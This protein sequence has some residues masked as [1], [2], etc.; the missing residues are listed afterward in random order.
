MLHPTQ[1]EEQLEKLQIKKPEAEQLKRIASLP[2][3]LRPAAYAVLNRDAAGKIASRHYNQIATSKVELMRLPKEDL[4]IIL[5]AFFPM[6]AEEVLLALKFAENLPYQAGYTQ[7]AFRYSRNNPH[8]F[9]VSAKVFS[10]I[11]NATEDYDQ[12]IHWFSQWAPY[13]Y[14]GRNLGT[15]FAAVID[16]GGERGERVYQ[17]MLDSA[18]GTHPIG[19]MG[20]H[21]AGALLMAS[22]PDGWEFMEKT[23]L[24][25]QRQEGLR[26]SIL[27]TVD[28]AH[29]T[30]FR[31]MLRL[32]LEHELFRFSAV[33][34]AFDLWLGFYFDVETLK[35]KQG[36]QMLSKL[37]GYIEEPE[38]RLQAALNAEHSDAYMALCAEGFENVDSAVE[39]AAQ[40]LD[41]HET[42]RRY[43]AIAFLEAAAT[44]EAVLAA[45]RAIKD[46]DLRIAYKAATICSSAGTGNYFDPT[47][48]EW[49][50]SHTAPLKDTGIDLFSELTSLL[51]RLPVKEVVLEPIVWE[52]TGVKIDR[53]DI[54]NS[55]NW[56]MQDRPATD[57]IPYLKLMAASIRGLALEKIVKLKPVTPQ[58]RTVL[59]DAFGDTSEDVRKAVKE[60]VKKLTLT[61]TEILNMERLLTRK[62]ADLRLSALEILLKQ[63]D[64]AS[65]ASAD[66]LLKSVAMQR[67][68]G[69]EILSQMASK[70][71]SKSACVERAAKY[72][73]DS[74]KLE[75]AEQVLLE[76]LLKEDSIVHGHDISQQLFDPSLCTPHTRKRDVP[77]PLID[78][79]APEAC[80]ESLSQLYK[81]HE[82][83][84]ITVRRYDGSPVEMLLCD[85]HLNLPN[86]AASLV[87]ENEIEEE[88]NYGER[89]GNAE[90][91]VAQEEFSFPLSEIWE[92]WSLK[93]SAEL[94]DE[95]GLE[96]LRLLVALDVEIASGYNWQKEPGVTKG[97]ADRIKANIGD[98]KV[99]FQHRIIVAWLL[100]LHPPTG[101]SDYLLNLLEYLYS[102]IPDEAILSTGTGKKKA[103][104]E[105][106][107]EWR[108]VY[109]LNSLSSTT[110]ETVFSLNPDAWTQSQKAR[111]W[112]LTHWTDRPCQSAQ[113]RLPS[114]NL[115]LAAYD[116]GIA[117]DADLFDHLIGERPALPKE[118]IDFNY[119]SMYSAYSELEA[120]TRR[121][122][123]RALA[124]HVPL[125]KV[126]DQI[127]DRCI[128]VE[129]S[130]GELP[131][132]VSE[133]AMSL[134][135]VKGSE[136]LKRF[137]TKF[138]NKEPFVRN[139]DHTNLTR[140]AVFSH[141]IRICS[142]SESDTYEQFAR[143]LNET[144][145]T[146]LRLVELAVFA[147]QW[148]VWVEKY[149]G[150]ELLEE[151]VWWLHAHT[152]DVGWSVDNALKEEWKAK[153]AT[154]TPLSGDD[155]IDGAADVDW[156]RRVFAAMEGDRWKMLDSAAKYASGGGGQKRAQLYADAMRGAL[157]EESLSARVADKRNLDAVR[158]IGLLPIPADSKAKETLLRRYG[159]LQEFIRTSRQFGA[160]RQ[161]SEKRAANIGK[162]N[163]SRSAGFADP[164]RLSW[165][166]EAE[167]VSDLARG[168]ISVSDGEVTITLSI[169]PDGK[170][171]LSVTKKGK[172]LKSIP[173]ALKKLPEIIELIER[174]KEI[175]KQS[176][177]MKRS[178]E[179]AM[180][181][182]DQ[183]Q[184][185]ELIE[186][187]KLP[188]LNPLLA[189]LVFVGERIAGCPGPDGTSLIDH[190]DSIHAIQAS[191]KLRLAHPCDLA[192]TGEWHL[193]QTH[194]YQREL[195][196][197]FKQ[198]FRELYTLLPVETESGRLRSSRYEGHQVMPRQGMA[199]LGG[200][201]WVNS[202]EEGVRRT[203]HSEKIQA[204]I[205]F[206]QYF[207]TPAEV[208][209]LTVMNV[210]FAKRNDSKRIPLRDVP[211]RL[212]SE[213]MRDI[214]LMVSVAHAGGVDPEASQSTVEMRESLLRETLRWLKISNVSYTGS[215]AL[216]K[217]HLGDYSIHMGSGVVHRQPGGYLCIVPVSSQHRG[218]LFLPFADN[219]P[220]TAEVISKVLLLA[221]DEEIRDP[222]ILQQIL[223]GG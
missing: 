102:L 186:L 66:R 55:L 129:L 11:L 97:I 19:A 98:K 135:M 27:E 114:I 155:L 190:D 105:F 175:D 50:P 35:P 181:R 130:R 198:L 200:R 69:L 92:E 188:A 182:G 62:T 222:I 59:L 61:D 80:L 173:P 70:E 141:F 220:K 171:D 172:P 9:E 71:R 101:A 99:N 58:V 53:S 123:N 113:R 177:R 126:V 120:C 214:D 205:E 203:F 5:P 134:Q 183:F 65:L 132:P 161:E 36:S 199:L 111:L 185:D 6:F 25:A 72:Q 30:A 121:R 206:E 110:I 160:Q 60:A 201:G 84:P 140:Q 95:D 208:E 108:D 150:W 147:P 52:W 67:A 219:D 158:A 82:K 93:R 83:T 33:L 38:T 116:H 64:E 76:G 218:R 106:Q 165:A 221:K 57:L 44:A 187:M 194:C 81:Q 47:D 51:E 170:P 41:H 119:Y 86:T 169:A 143:Q 56:S 78:T 91:S 195:A 146:Q 21:V 122:P 48:M 149:L 118:Y 54:A 75:P 179:E 164:I 180:C 40:I 217:G 189:K 210:S 127:R 204:H 115:L 79:S 163:L 223:P 34:R 112:Q 213:T 133:Q 10:D 209:G 212:F 23:L 49:K 24:A 197:P 109:A 94:R 156:F 28:L 136:T 22:R 167:A 89:Q 4:R 162:E 43:I 20:F 45:S 184:G 87:A 2:E 13:F 191:D 1:A 138:G 152:K 16:A 193:W 137:L 166:M 73:A 29:P 77:R 14:N 90:G 176:S 74:K 178:L 202:A 128:E 104:F 159:I 37:L 151:S 8:R 18:R 68:A 125:M 174:K 100:K 154:Y 42:E 17:T 15:L 39:I 32:I 153:A 196:Q 96:L 88:L 107:Q 131:T 31:R 148:A 3:R 157:T 207:T 63:S 215:H 139:A 85:A 144:N 26:Q 145:V 124:D 216:V 192:R 7:K 168:P 142:P 103:V 117:N 46:P 211:E 12:D